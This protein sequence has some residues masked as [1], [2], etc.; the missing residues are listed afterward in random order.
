MLFCIGYT[1]L[2]TEETFPL[3]NARDEITWAKGLCGFQV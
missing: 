1:S 2:N 3:D